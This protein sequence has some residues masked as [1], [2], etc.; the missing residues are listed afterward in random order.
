MAVLKA[1]T[2]ELPCPV[3]ISSS[4][5]IIWSS[6]TGRSTSGKMAGDIIAEKKNLDIKWEYLSEDD[7]GLIKRNLSAGFFP[8]TFRDDGMEI[9]IQSYRGTLSK[10]HLGYVGDGTYYYRSVSVQIIEQ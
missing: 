6:N 2:V 8:L 5:E 3:S 4:D 9:T 7:V 10:E 1:G